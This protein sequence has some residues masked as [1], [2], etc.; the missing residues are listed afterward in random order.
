MK[1]LLL[2]ALVFALATPAHANEAE[3]AA[4]AQVLT[5]IDRR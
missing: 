3:D 4:T 1:H 2:T 5:A